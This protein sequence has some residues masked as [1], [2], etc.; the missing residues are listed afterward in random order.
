MQCVELGQRYNSIKLVK[1]A[2]RKARG[3]WMAITASDAIEYE[4]HVGMQTGHEKGNS[5]SQT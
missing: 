5:Q 3:Y 4:L 1:E 2:E